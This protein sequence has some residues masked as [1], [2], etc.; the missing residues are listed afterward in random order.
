MATRT[1]TKSRAVHGLVDEYGQVAQTAAR[2]RDGRDADLARIAG[3]ARHL[4]PASP[5]R[6]S[7]TTARSVLLEDLSPE[8][9]QTVIGDLLDVLVLRRLDS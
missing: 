3:H 5:S 6:Q 8:V 1:N 2:H 9:L 7:L 4:P